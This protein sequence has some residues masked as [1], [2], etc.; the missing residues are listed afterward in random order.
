MSSSY[1]PLPADQTSLV[2]PP[3]TIVLTVILLVFFFL[4][5]FS[6]YFCRCFMES[7]VNNWH[8]RRSTSG[9]NLNPA[10]SPANNGLDPALIQIFPTFSYSSVKDFRREKYGL[11]CAVCLAEFEDDDVLRLLTVCYHVFHQECI[12]LWLES[13]KTCPV[14]RS[15][16]DLPRETLEKTPASEQNNDHQTNNNGTLAENAIS[17]DIAED[18]DGDQKE[19]RSG[20][21]EG[22][23]VGDDANKQNQ[24]HEK[25][26][27]FSRSHSTGHSIVVARE[28]EDRYTLRLLDHVKVKFS[29]GHNNSE[30]CITFGDFT[31]PTNG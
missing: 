30:S 21:A 16:L 4:G 17:I 31:S 9:N 6:I 18:D 1:P 29:K 11:E 26:E 8:L 12:D 15:D 14:C 13:H 22:N 10:S 28:E 20:N 7:V 27:R 25:I 23:L 3:I 2:S 5:F 19:G 24:S